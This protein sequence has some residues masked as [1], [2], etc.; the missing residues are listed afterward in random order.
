MKPIALFPVAVLLA[1]LTS[2]GVARI[3][4]ASSS[5]SQVAPPATREEVAQLAQTL[6]DLQTRQ[7]SLT[8][9]VEGLRSELGSRA[10]GESRV[11]V[12][13]IEAA[14]ARALA[15][16][17]APREFGTMLATKNA[18]RKPFDKAAALQALTAPGLAWEDAQKIWRDAADAGMLDEML[19]F[20]E[21]RATDDPRNPQAQVDLAQAYLQQVFHTEEGPKKGIWATKA[22]KAFDAA[23]AIDEHHWQARF[24]KAVSLSFWPP[25]FGKQAEAIRHFEMLVEQQAQQPSRPEF[26]QTWLYLGNMY[27][28]SG[29]AEKALSAWQQGL[30]LFPGNAALQ[31]QIANA[32][33]H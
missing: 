32:Q 22:D 19:A 1:A 18:A 29:N 11:P 25:I 9:S 28:Q 6:A 20:M 3:A 2:Y 33:G 26:S 5:S 21:Q 4:T 16:R 31:Q 15:G 10:S 23:L 14:V 27:Q 8:Q 24:S 30:A 13:E 12:G 7:E 17:E